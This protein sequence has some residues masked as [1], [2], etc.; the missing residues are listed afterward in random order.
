MKV[1]IYSLLLFVFTFSLQANVWRVNN[2]DS[3]AHFSD[4]TIAHDDANVQ[5]GDTL[6]VEGS[7][8]PYSDL[9]CIKKLTIIGPGYLLNTN[10]QTANM[11]PAKVSSIYFDKGSEGS[12]V[13]GISFTLNAGSTPIIGTDD[14]NVIRCSINAYLPIRNVKNIRVINNYMAG[15][16]DYYN[17]TS[18]F[19]DVYI[20]NN[21]I[22]NK[23]GITAS[24]NFIAF[25]NNILLGESYG[26]NAEYF[27]NNIITRSFINMSVNSGNNSNNIG[28]NNMLEGNNINVENIDSLFIGGDSP[29]G[30]YMLSENSAAKAAGFEGTDC[31]IFGGDEPYVLSGIPPLPTIIELEVDDATTLDE[32]LKV[33]VKIHAK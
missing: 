3:T 16:D 13:I 21:I 20:K 10:Y 17:G 7:N 12:S 27:R 5:D 25:D 14:I 8:T 31:G 18:V 15:V 11:L 4:I 22:R 26:F 19:S 30:K 23:M 2:N 6:M 28:T 9:T 29:D 1:H 24:S 33:K 32:G